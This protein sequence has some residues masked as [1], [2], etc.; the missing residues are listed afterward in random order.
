MKRE[1]VVLKLDRI[2][3]ETL[4][5]VLGRQMIENKVATD[6]YLNIRKQLNE[7]VG[8]RSDDVVNYLYSILYSRSE[9]AVP[10]YTV[11]RDTAEMIAE[12][13]KTAKLAQFLIE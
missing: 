6:T 10:D 5:N 11:L 7:D 2:D 9:A 4:M 1:Y 8:V 13:L 3:A 12:G